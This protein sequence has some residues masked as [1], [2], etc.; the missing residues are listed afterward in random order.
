MLHLYDLNKVK[1]HGLKQYKDL[2]IE[3]TLSSGD[4]VLSFLFPSKLSENIKEEGYIR[5]KT[6]EFVIKV[7]ADTGDW[8]SIKATLNIEALEGQ[9]WEHF[10]TTEQ[11]I[12]NCLNLAIA[13]TGWTIG[14]CNVTKKRTIRKTNCSTWDIIQ[15]AKKTYLAEISFDTINKKINIFEKMGSDKGVYFIDSLNLKD[16][17]IQSDSYDFYTKL[18]AIGKDDLKVEVENYQYS[19]KKKTF[20][21]K[22]ERYTNIDSL[23]EDAAAKLNELSKPYRAYSVNVL[24]L[25]KTDNKYKILDYKLGDTITLIS[26]DKRIK[27]RQRIFKITE[28]PKEPEKNTCEVANTLLRFED[29]QKEQQDTTDT[30]NNITTDNGTVDGSA[31]NSIKTEQISDFEVSVGKITNLTAINIRV[32]NLYAKKADID[33][34]NAVEIRV[35]SLIATKANI[36]QLD[37]EVARINQA[38][39]KT[40]TIEN[41]N[42]TNGKITLLETKVGSIDTILSKEIFAELIS[43]GKIVAGSSI[44]AEGA[45]GSAQISSLSATK[46]SAGI[47]DAAVITVKN[48]NA[49]NITVGSINGKR[50]AEGAIDNSKVAEGANISGNK[51]NINDVIVNINGSTTQINGTKIQV[52]DRT[53]DVELST[54]KIVLEENKTTISK[55]QATINAMDHAIKLKVDN[56][57]FNNFKSTTEGNIVT[58]TTNL[59]KATSSIDV[60]QKEIALKVEQTDINKVSELAT[61]MSNGKMLYKNPTFTPFSR[62]NPTDTYNGIKAYNNSGNNLVNLMTIEDTLAPNPNKQVIQVKTTGVV[63]PGHGG[64]YFGTQSRANAIFVTRIIAKIPIGFSL[65]FASN[66]YGIGGTQKWLT[67]VAGTDKWEEYIC[68]VTCGNSG[69]FSSTNFFYLIGSAFTPTPHRPLMWSIAYAT[70]FDTTDTDPD[71][72]VAISSVE[73]KINTKV[74]DINV[75]LDGITSRVGKTESATTT[76][77]GKVT[78]LSTRVATAEQKITPDGIVATVRNSTAYKGDLNGKANQTALTTAESKITQLTDLISHKVESKDFTS[79]KTQTDKAITDRVSNGTFNTYKTQTASEMAQRVSKGEFGS[80]FKQNADSFD[81]GFSG[82]VNLLKNSNFALERTNW[83]FEGGMESWIMNKESQYN[84]FGV[85]NQVMIDTKV[86]NVLYQWNV[87]AR[88]GG[89]YTVSLDYNCYTNVKFARI[90]IAWRDK[91]KELSRSHGPTFLVNGNNCKMVYTATAP[92]GTQYCVIMVQHGGAKDPKSDARIRMANLMMVEGKNPAN[93]APHPSEFNNTSVT[94]TD[95]EGLVVRNNAISVIS[96][97]GRT[98]FKVE[99]DGY[100]ANEWGVST[101]VKPGTNISVQGKIMADDKCSTLLRAFGLWHESVDSKYNLRIG[102]K[103]EIWFKNLADDWQDTRA[104]WSMASQFRTTYNNDAGVILRE[105]Q[106]DSGSGRLWLNYAGGSPGNIANTLIGDGMSA[107]SYGN[108]HCGSLYTHGTKNRAVETIHFGT[109]ALGAYETPTPYF[110]DISRQIFEVIDGQ[111]IVPIDP[112]F[113]ETITDTGEYQVFF[114]KYGPG[115]IWTAEMYPTYFIVKGANIKFS[116]ELKAI[117]RG[118]ENNR[119]EQVQI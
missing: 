99:D 93:W 67:P 30:V 28:Y 42:A 18:I 81:F 118:Y 112:I 98:A 79:Y 83:T 7:I 106:V 51:L 2:S 54:Q 89:D 103:S 58:V 60:L 34:L 14:S 36:T 8:K 74:G 102:S 66:G 107:G 47:I 76:V 110:G 119:L 3:S 78:A 94:I 12:N 25:S 15:Q 65:V 50:I 111:C 86:S 62:E 10:D 39:I 19:N 29:T 53:L 109:R 114:S 91:A 115:D 88:G 100:I 31:I 97:S 108:L 11:S 68:K 4:K 64:F 75:S 90:V 69:A 80:L 33:S 49:D 52:G 61:A 6:D 55:Q 73:T 72:G 22:D 26:K 95:A 101:R 9:P 84:L 59:N 82:G 13:G 1:I 113:K 23:K 57:T 43:A 46:L 20:I 63:T 87:N 24:D 117:Q 85:D 5:T 77:D 44:I 37:A 40:A 48:L 16:L 32:D 71:Y 116:W 38:F 35:G 17:D 27:E 56:Q 104:R 92:A 45:I 70:V 105:N 96:K 21:W 41:L